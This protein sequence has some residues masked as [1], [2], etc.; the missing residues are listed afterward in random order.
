MASDIGKKIRKLMIDADLT[1]AEIARKARCTRQNVT[2]VIDGKVKDS[3]VKKILAKRL[4][5]SITDL[6]PDANKKETKHIG[7]N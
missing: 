5:K 4:G 7:T 1:A 6:W 3:P 2:Y